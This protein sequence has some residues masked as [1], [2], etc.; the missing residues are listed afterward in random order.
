MAEIGQQVFLSTGPKKY[1]RLYRE[2]YVQPIAISDPNWNVLRLGVSMAFSNTLDEGVHDFWIGFCSGTTNTLASGAC[3]HFMGYKMDYQRIVTPGSG[4]RYVEIAGSW[5][6]YK[7]IN[8]VFNVYAIGSFQPVFPTNGGT[9]LRRG[10]LS[11]SIIKWN[12]V[13]AGGVNTTAVEYDVTPDEF[14]SL[15]ET[16]GCKLRGVDCGNTIQWPGGSSTV[17]LDTINI[18]WGSGVHPIEIYSVGAYA[19]YQ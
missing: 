14:V 6:A 3:T 19:F 9:L 7:V 4:N 11:I 1:L 13:V 8:G 16:Y 12:T 18:Y 10:F 17:P 2:E 5:G 15:T